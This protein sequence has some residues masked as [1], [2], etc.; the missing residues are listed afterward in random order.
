MGAKS[1]KI[2][3]PIGN[4]TKARVP[5]DAVSKLSN[6]DLHIDT[7][8]VIIDSSLSVTILVY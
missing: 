4:T 1:T 6:A 8:L 5:C 2:H 3:P 7:F